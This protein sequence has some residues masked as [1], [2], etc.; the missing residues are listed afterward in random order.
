M[1]H[2]KLNT[3]QWLALGEKLGYIENGQIKESKF[4]GMFGSDRR[5]WHG[6]GERGRNFDEMAEH[7]K[8]DMEEYGISKQMLAQLEILSKKY[9]VSLGTLIHKM[10]ETGTKW[11]DTGEF[12]EPDEWGNKYPKKRQ[13]EVDGET[14]LRELEQTLERDKKTGEK[15]E[16]FMEAYEIKDRNVAQIVMNR[17]KSG[18]FEPDRGGRLVGGARSVV[19]WNEQFGM[20][21]WDSIDLI[22][23]AKERNLD[24]NDLERRL[25]VMHSKGAIESGDGLVDSIFSALGQ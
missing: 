6:F 7:H 8:E 17:M 21:P 5:R 3:K 25:E 19:R 1:A 12:E 20:K 24:L 14:R 2:L 9:N 11:E 13:V 15:I 16:N 10:S 18:D 22:E 23:K 4:L